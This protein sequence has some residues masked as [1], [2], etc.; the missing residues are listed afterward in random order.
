MQT[1]IVTTLQVIQLLLALLTDAL[2]VAS[3]TSSHVTFTCCCLSHIIPRHVLLLLP[4]AHHPTSRSLVVA[5]RTSSHVTF[6]CCCLSHIIPR[7]VL[8]LLPLA[9][10]PTSR[11]L[12]FSAK[13][14]MTVSDHRSLSSLCILTQSF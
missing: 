11:S 13:L 9:H 12:C 5:S 14:L 4:L 7:H 3:R 6:S 10:H 8:L 1:D 2:V